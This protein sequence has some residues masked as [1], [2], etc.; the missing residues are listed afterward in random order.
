MQT[1]RTALALTGDG[2][3]SLSIKTLLKPRSLQNIHSIAHYYLDYDPELPTVHDGL[4][5]KKSCG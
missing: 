1:Q 5:V 4:I 3:L 2:A